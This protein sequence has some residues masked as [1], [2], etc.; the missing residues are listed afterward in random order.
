MSTSSLSQSPHDI[1]RDIRRVKTVKQLSDVYDS[2][3]GYLRR[4]LAI[5]ME[6]AR[7]HAHRSPRDD[8]TDG[9]TGIP[10]SMEHLM[11]CSLLTGAFC[12]QVEHL[13]H[14]WRAY[15]DVEV[16]ASMK[17]STTI[18]ACVTELSQLLL[19][20]D[21]P[22]VNTYLEYH[23]PPVS[24]PPLHSSPPS[25]VACALAYGLGELEDYHVYRRLR[26][27]HR[28]LNLI[29][30]PRWDTAAITQAVVILNETLREEGADVALPFSASEDGV[31]ATCF[32]TPLR[33][34]ISQAVIQ[35]PVRGALCCHVELFDLESFVKVTHQRTVSTVDVGSPCPICS[36]SVLLASIRVDSLAWD[37]MRDF[38]RTKAESGDGKASSATSGAAACSTLTADCVLEWDTVAKTVRVVAAQRHHP[39]SSVT[40]LSR[41]GDGVAEAER[42]DDEAPSNAQ[43]GVMKRRRIEIGGHVLY[44]D[45]E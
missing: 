35:V 10:S 43:S 3:I 19:S 22:L 14:S 17:S 12:R 24:S 36:K 15:T 4:H 40:T 18:S 34:P 42:E 26:T 11:Q 6:A 25:R 31:E 13:L 16:V 45:D 21:T 29:A 37:A 27:Q 9:V 2:L 1:L 5:V 39:S 23:S 44:A 41:P 38:S 7:L 28:F 30:Q 33:D 20:T 32:V 8:G